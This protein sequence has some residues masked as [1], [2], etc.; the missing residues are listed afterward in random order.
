MHVRKDCKWIQKTAE[1]LE[2]NIF[3]YVKD[4]RLVTPYIKNSR[5][6]RGKQGKNSTE[7]RTKNIDRQLKSQLWRWPL[8]LRRNAIFN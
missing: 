5:N 7:Q 3:T 8:N 1:K 6:L 4:K 2:K